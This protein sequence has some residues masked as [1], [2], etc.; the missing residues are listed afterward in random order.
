MDL[1]IKLGF[2]FMGVTAVCAEVRYYVPQVTVKQVL[3]RLTNN[4]FALDDPQCIFQQYNTSDVWI[5]IALDNVVPSLTVQNVGKPSGYNLFQTKK[6][7]HLYQMPANNY[8]CSDAQPKDKALIPVGT[9]FNCNNVSFCNGI[10]TNNGPY[11]VKFVLLN[12]TAL[13]Q[14]TRWSEKFNL[15]TGK[16]TTTIDIGPGGRSAG[17]IVIVVILS[18][19]L[20]LL[21]AFLIAALAIGSKDICWCRVLENEFLGVELNY[22]PRYQTHKFY[23][24]HSKWFTPQQNNT[25]VYT[26]FK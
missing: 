14:E 6:Y 1:I 8:T 7:Y 12:S 9:Q 19:L 26:V 23:T 25:S 3:G 18:V 11:R 2:L 13:V 5:V 20:T 22:I 10:L 24:T 16:N 4:S 21:L 17:M 15:L